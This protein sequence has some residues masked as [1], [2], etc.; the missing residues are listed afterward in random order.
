VK[1]D[2]LGDARDRRVLRNVKVPMRDGIGL[3]TTICLPP[4]NGP[5]PVV[6]VRTAYN[7]VGLRSPEY[8]SRGIAFIQL[9]G[10]ESRK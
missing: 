7:R 10:A 8:W 4:G 6:L 3:S 9:F 1:P 2:S 5:F